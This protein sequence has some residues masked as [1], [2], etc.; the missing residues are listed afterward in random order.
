MEK[1]FVEGRSALTFLEYSKPFLR[2]GFSP[3]KWLSKDQFFTHHLQR[4]SRVL[5]MHFTAGSKVVTSS[6]CVESRW[7]GLTPQPHSGQHDSLHP[8]GVRVPLRF[9][10]GAEPTIALLSP[11]SKWSKYFQHY[12][13]HC[14]VPDSSG[15][16]LIFSFLSICHLSVLSC[17]CI[18][19]RDT[20]DPC[21][22]RKDAKKVNRIQEPRKQCH[23]GRK[24]VENIT[25]KWLRF[26]TLIVQ[27]E[28]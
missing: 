13:E 15:R 17:P 25:L 23:L 14:L 10:A 6:G 18:S 9:K 19:N 2:E 7:S 5:S 28:R 4:G 12:R 1:I 26:S 11:G 24:R 21:F 8:L 3:C 27:E 22:W 20:E 16:F